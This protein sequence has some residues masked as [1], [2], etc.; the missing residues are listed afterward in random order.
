MTLF[1][2]DFFKASF[3]FDVIICLNKIKDAGLIFSVQVDMPSIVSA[4]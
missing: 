2:F 3:I 4:E 1:S